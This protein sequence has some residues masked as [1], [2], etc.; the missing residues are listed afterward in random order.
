MITDKQIADVLRDFD[1]SKVC[2]VYELFRWEWAPI[3]R[4]PNERDL[5]KQ[6]KEYLKDLQS[7]YPK[8]SAIQSGGIKV[9]AYDDEEGRTIVEL[10]FIAHSSIA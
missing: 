7:K 5:R 10:L 2:S 4:T 9:D 3:G 6:A 8:V 1:F